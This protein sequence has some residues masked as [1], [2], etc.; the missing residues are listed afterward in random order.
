MSCIKLK[1]KDKSIYFGENSGFF[2]STRIPG[3]IMDRLNTN[4]E[5]ENNNHI[6]TIN[7]C[8]DY[9]IIDE[10]INPSSETFNL[11]YDTLISILNHIGQV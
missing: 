5:K 3:N 7:L 9:G 1:V 2:G 6:I 4:I 10:Y 8:D 11:S